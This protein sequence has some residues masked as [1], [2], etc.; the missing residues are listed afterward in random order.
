M[1]IIYYVLCKNFEDPTY[2][3]GNLDRKTWADAPM[4]R[5]SCMFGRDV[6]ADKNYAMRIWSPCLSGILILYPSQGFLKKTLV[7][8]STSLTVVSQYKCIVL[9]YDFRPVSPNQSLPFVQLV[10]RPSQDERLPWNNI[11]L[12]CLMVMGIH[13]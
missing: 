6:A 9:A 11:L 3:L 5:M 10:D 7:N 2:L 12:H 8:T 4:S 13:D 1:C